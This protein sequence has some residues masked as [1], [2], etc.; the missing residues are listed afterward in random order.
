MWCELRC[1]L[2]PDGSADEHRAEIDKYFEGRLDEPVQVLVAVDMHG[3][4]AGLVELSIRSSAAGCVTNRIGYLEGWYVRPEVRCLG[5]G[6]ALVAAA[7]NWAR[8]QGCTEFASDADPMNSAS[9]AAHGAIGFEA[10]G[11]GRH[12]RKTLV[13]S[14]E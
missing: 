5:I 12:F 10:V 13:A 14:S 4:I 9:L 3:T 6:R 8:R 7:E 2:W 1:A 11:D